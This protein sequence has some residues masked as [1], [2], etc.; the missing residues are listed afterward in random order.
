MTTPLTANQITLLNKSVGQ[1]V[2]NTVLHAANPNP[3]A[4]V[5]APLDPTKIDA[6]YAAIK[7]LD[8]TSAVIPII[9]AFKTDY[10]TRL[11]ATLTTL[12]ADASTVQVEIA[13]VTALT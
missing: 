8:N 11:N 13:A 6:I 9:D 7:V 4:L 12:N 10:L 1:G 2:W 5:F 3:A